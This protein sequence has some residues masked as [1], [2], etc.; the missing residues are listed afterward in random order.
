MFGNGLTSIIIDGGLFIIAATVFIE[1]AFILGFFLPGDTL[2][3]LAGFIAGQGRNNIVF[4]AA[5]ILFAATLG[6]MVGYSIGRRAGPKFF[7][8]DDGILF[9]KRYVLQAQ[10]FY[11]KHG[12]KTLILAR[13]IPVVRTFAPLVAGIG[14][15]PFHRFL[16]FS[17]AGAALWAVLIPGIGFW[18]YRV[19]G[20]AI[21]I[22]KYVMPVVLGIMI[23]SIGG[24]AFHAIRE[25]K[26][27]RRRRRVTTA[28]LEKNQAEAE[29][30]LE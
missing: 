6:N 29:T 27:Q 2:L 4:T 16:F 9:Q 10:E 25:G 26:K 5:L 11:E 20:H 18:A 15:M 17:T 13:F 8:K 24:S 12:G 28:D 19:L 22:E 30:H 14:K 23:I 1:C 7:T 21:D 3:F